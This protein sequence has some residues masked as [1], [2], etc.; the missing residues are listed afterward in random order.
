M[1]NEKIVQ[2]DYTKKFMTSSQKKK[3]K[4]KNG[5]IALFIYLQTSISM[6]VFYYYHH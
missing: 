6:D 4:T 3:K 2:N 1:V 5:K